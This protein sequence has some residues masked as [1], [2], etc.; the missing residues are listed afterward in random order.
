MNIILESTYLCS[1]VDSGSLSKR[2]NIKLRRKKYFFR[3]YFSSVTLQNKSYSHSIEEVRSNT[4]SDK[5]EWVCHSVIEKKLVWRNERPDWQ[6]PC[7]NWANRQVIEKTSRCQTSWWLNHDQLW[8]YQWPNLSH[9]SW[10]FER[11]RWVK[12]YLLFKYPNI[13]LKSHRQPIY[14]R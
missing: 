3:C 4:C 8:N 13:I 2:L 9:T 7:S 11:L 1:I 12:M 5:S 10:S 6:K 14:I